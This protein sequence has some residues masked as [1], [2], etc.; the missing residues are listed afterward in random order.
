[1]FEILFL[2]IIIMFFSEND[3]IIVDGNML[4]I[5]IF[6]IVKILKTIQLPAIP[7]F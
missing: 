6:D 7:L 3:Y 2:S 5:E 1:M 4:F